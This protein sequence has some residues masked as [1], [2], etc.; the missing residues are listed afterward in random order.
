MPNLVQALFDG[1]VD[2]VGDIH[3]EIAALDAL[4][5][6]LG[7]NR[8][9]RHRSGR[10]LV[11]VGDL[12]DR[13]ANS[14]AVVERVADMVVAGRAQCVLGNHELNLL[15]GD[16]KEGNG[17]FY[18]TADDHDQARGRF[19]HSVRAS[20]SQRGHFL[21]WFATLPIALERPDL[22]VVHACWHPPHIEALR[23]D[24]RP[25]VEIHDDYSARIDAQLA[26]DGYHEAAEQER[27]EWQEHLHD[28]T[29]AM[30]LLPALGAI[31]SRQQT[32]NPIRVSTSGMERPTAAPFF[33]SGK[34]RMVERVNWWQDYD[35]EPRVVFG[36]YWRWP[37]DGADALRRHQGP[38]P[39]AGSG[40][41]D[42][43][44]PRGNAM[45]VDWCVGARWSEA[46]D[47]IDG[48][49]VALGALRSDTGTVVLDR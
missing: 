18:P 39:F 46:A 13:G 44:G 7:Y 47:E 15:L 23:N 25:V 30:P 5:A 22:R 29:V 4:L 32:R 43:L 9:G 6:R 35:D 26:A 11:F 8:D 16:H 21:E 1:P 17:W 3:G 20:D 34:W 33:V 45:C 28:A 38:Y 24:R 10:Q 27:M 37:F 2:V 36:H 31:D 41:F 14:P 40:P 12:V 49:R 19:P 48:G 42:W